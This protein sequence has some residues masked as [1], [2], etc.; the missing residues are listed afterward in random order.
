MNIV[1]LSILALYIFSTG[2][3]YLFAHFK[4][5]VFCLNICSFSLFFLILFIYLFLLVYFKRN[6]KKL[7]QKSICNALMILRLNFSIFQEKKSQTFDV[8]SNLLHNRK[9]F[10]NI[11]FFKLRH[12]ALFPLHIRENFMSFH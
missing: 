11:T 3:F 9:Y 6:Q 10:P 4:I 8:L 12:F 5:F 1:C 2:D 7:K